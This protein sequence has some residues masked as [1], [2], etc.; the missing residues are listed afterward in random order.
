MTRALVLIFLFIVSICNAQGWE[1]SFDSAKRK[2][3]ATNKLMLVDFWATWCGPCKRMDMDA[4]SN[5]KVK[6]VMEHFV[7]VKV[8]IDSDRTT[9]I[10]YGI[11]GI[12]N[13][14]IMDANGKV[15]HDFSGYHSAEEVIK[16]IEKFAL[17]TE[18]VSREL[19]GF[20]KNNGCNE[21]IRLAQKYYDFSLLVDKSVKF[22]FTKIAG[23]YLEDS[24][25]KLNKKEANYPVVSQ[26]IALFELY[27]SLYDYDF[28]KVTKKL[29]KLTQK[30]KIEESN[31]IFYCFLKYAA[32][33]GLNTQDVDQ[34]KQQLMAIEGHEVMLEKADFILSKKVS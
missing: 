17:S 10:R 14:F 29:E 6:L 23:T 19:M 7:P 27:G 22:K 1:T 8:D 11:N 31:M 2:A 20:S 24:E 4:W 15:V 13:M 21:G 28:E 12:P 5:D 3:L 9:S 25:K 26:R 33:K 34:A 32:A 18:F 30:N 16:E